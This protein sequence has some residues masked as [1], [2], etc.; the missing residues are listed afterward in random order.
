MSINTRILALCE[1]KKLKQ[2]DLVELGFGAKQTIN[3]IFRSKQNPNFDFVLKILTH[4]KDIDARWLITGDGE[5]FAKDEKNIDIKGGQNIFADDIAQ[6]GNKNTLQ[7][8]EG[9]AAETLALRKELD[10]KTKEIGL[11]QK[12]LNNQEKLIARYEKLLDL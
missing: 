3:N 1:S 7:N 8:K 12:Q 10:L 6:Y 11:Q 4:Y 2:F 5:M 9:N